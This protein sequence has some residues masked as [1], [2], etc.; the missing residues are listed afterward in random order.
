MATFD[1]LIQE[2]GARYHLG[3]KARP[4]VQE[5]LGLIAE[6]PG[7][8]GCFLNKFK[9][10][11]FAA[12]A[13]SWLGDAPAVPLSGQQIEQALGC[14]VINR[15]A[16]EIGISQGFT[17]TV[18]GYTLPKI[19][20]FLAPGG[21]VPLEIPASVSSFLVS[22]A[23]TEKITPQRGEQIPPRRIEDRDPP[24]LDWLLVPGA[25][26]LITLGVLG[27][28]ISSGR[29]NDRVAVRPAP[30][31]AQ[32]T[33]VATP[34]TPSI[35][36]RLAL[37]NENGHII[38]SAIVADSATRAAI[39]DALDRVFGA[40]KTS[41]EVAVDPRAGPAEWIKTLRPALSNF[42]TPRSQALFEGS[43]LKV[44]GA[45]PKKDRIR[46]ISSLK[47]IFGSQFV[48][49]TLDGGAAKTAAA[50]PKS[51]G[52]AKDLVSI[53]TQSAVNFP[54][55]DFAAGGAE[56]PLSSKPLL[57]QAARQMKQMPAG[58]VI[59]IGGYTDSTGNPAA[60]MQLSQ[61]RANAVRRALIRAGVNPAM[62]NAKGYGS[63]KSLASSEGTME[64]RSNDTM[65]SSL[66]KERRVEFRVIQP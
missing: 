52:S 35:S 59:E 18:L 42:K 19:I 46:I 62:L 20:A 60:N 64:G 58:T 1:E 41:G 15:I 14:E 30:V 55:I 27:Y 17:G 61:Q 65:E 23:R 13:A 3:S 31:V 66:R 37:T 2:I 54:T 48:F 32:N 33:P 47:S 5:A 56:V 34:Q 9:A 45:I 43:E 40:H 6:E 12:E 38:Y 50:T 44:G 53:P 25:A 29:T 22:S 11:G 63:P 36:A 7:G 8:I 10:A 24:R 39:T 16:N 26:L 51:G 4:L 28:F 57:R 21:V 49:A